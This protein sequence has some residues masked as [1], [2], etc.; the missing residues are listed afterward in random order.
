MPITL[1]RALPL[2]AAA[3]T[4][5][6]VLA[7]TGCS[8]GQSSPETTTSAPGDASTSAPAADASSEATGGSAEGE[9]EQA[10]AVS[11]SP[12]DCLVAE[13][14]L[15]DLKS[16]S[17]VDC[18][19]EHTAE[20]LW[21]VPEA[22]PAAEDAADTESACRAQSEAYLDQTGVPLTSTELRNT[23]DMTQHCVVYTLTDPWTGQVADTSVT[24]E[25]ALAA[26]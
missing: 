9:T 14:G 26:Q 15:R 5:A 18:T 17:T 22:D 6:A 13:P 25:T 24:L 23:A 1:H 21:A 4:A 8:G 16:F 2:R 19:E 10:E 11:F 7:L 20:Y 3:L 12:G